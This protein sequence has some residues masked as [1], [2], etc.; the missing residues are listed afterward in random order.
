MTSKQEQGIAI[1]P[2][3]GGLVDPVQNRCGGPERDT[4]VTAVHGAVRERPQN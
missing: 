1:D 4:A 2:G 3:Q